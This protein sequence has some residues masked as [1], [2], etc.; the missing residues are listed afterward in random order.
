MKIQFLFSFLLSI[1][2]QLSVFSQNNITI[3]DNSSHEANESAVLDVYSTSKGMLVP[4]MNTDQINLISAPANGL[5]V[6]NTDDN[7]FWFYNGTA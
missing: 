1:G 6:F 7:S 2:I 5:L 4:R 3:T